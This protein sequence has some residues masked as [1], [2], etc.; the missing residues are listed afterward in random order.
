[1]FDTLTTSF[2]GI[3]NKI[4]FLDDEK[5]LSR[6][7]DELKKALLKNDVYHKVAKDIV[8][9]VENECKK[10]GIGKDSFSKALQDSL[11]SVFNGNYGF[12]FAP[13]PP[14][15][16]LMVGL[17]GSGKTTS[18]AKLANYL[19]LRGKK[20]L[21]VACDLQRLAAV[22]QLKQLANEIEVDIFIK[23]NTK[24]KIVAQDSIKFAQNSNY[25]VIIIDTA[26]RLAI[27]AEL[28]DELKEIKATTKADEI[29]YVLDSLSGQDAIKSAD[30]FN[31]EIGLSGIILSKFDSDAKGGIALSVSKQINVPI[32]FIGSGE[33]IADLDIFLPDRI[34]GRLMGAGDVAGF[35]EKTTAVVDEKEAKRLTKKI[36][37]GEFT[38]NDFLSQLENIKKMGSMKSLI[39]MMPGL[40]A[41]G[42]ALKNVDI[43]NSVEIK[44]IKAMVSS[45]TQKER[46]NP[47]IL[48]GSRRKRIANGCGLDVS[49]INRSLKQF[50]TAA[51]MA[52][53]MSSPNGVKNI[54]NMIKGANINK[55]R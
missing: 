49:D 37:K 5:A 55:I 14:T 25:D 20:V 33:K 48:N 34:V 9:Q 13:K 47:S 26:G 15:V 30:N 53:Q 22:E 19:K 11:Y 38:F 8:L 4:R 44:N 7:L 1:M 40:G 52:K 41:M 35:I 50:E 23:E 43:D 46:E 24:P 51:K 2:R 17:Q 45:M 32:R 10:N 39:S 16:V 36:K 3:V 42:D 29:F 21:L 27:N 18:S 31:K 12:S 28:M 54:M 6:G